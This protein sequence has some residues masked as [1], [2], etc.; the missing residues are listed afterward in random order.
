[1]GTKGT[2]CEHC[3]TIA[4]LDTRLDTIDTTLAVITQHVELLKKLVYGAVAA[5]LT[6]AVT[7][8]A[9]KMVEALW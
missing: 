7:F 5:I 1:M 3:D 9:S 8:G 4:N 2:C 6:S